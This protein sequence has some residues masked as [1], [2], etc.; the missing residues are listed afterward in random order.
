MSDREDG[1]VVEGEVRQSREEKYRDRRRR[2]E[3]M[4][5]PRSS[6]R[7]NRSASRS[8]SRSRWGGSRSREWR[9]ERERS[10]RRSRSRDRSYRDRNGR[11]RQELDRGGYSEKNS[12]RKYREVRERRDLGRI[13][14][15]DRYERGRREEREGGG[16]EKGDFRRGGRERNGREEVDRTYRED[17]AEK[18]KRATSPGR[19]ENGVHAERERKSDDRTTDKG[20]EEKKVSEAT[21]A[22]EE[23]ENDESEE[24]SSIHSGSEDSEERLI[25][26]RR[27]KRQRLLEKLKRENKLDQTHSV[28]GQPQSSLVQS[29]STG[30]NEESNNLSAIPPSLQEVEGGAASEH[31]SLE[32]GDEADQGSRKLAEEESDGLPAANVNASSTKSEARQIRDGLLRMREMAQAEEVDEVE[33]TSKQK[34]DTE[35][36]FDMFA[37]SPTDAKAE[38]ILPSDIKV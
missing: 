5:S 3:V 11:G 34:A 10:E 26:E 38:A 4:S 14:E 17:R 36:I 28:L 1:E 13:N 16:Y 30:A 12:R 22:V 33:V 8:R 7:R 6:K 21:P 15:R 37:D 29:T 27:E 35:P 18:R 20:T 19:K 24:E 2:R 32:D 9:S 31:S 25:R 23:V